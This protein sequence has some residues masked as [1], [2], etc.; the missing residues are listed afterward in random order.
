MFMDQ[1]ASQ[2]LEQ[3]DH[4]LEFAQINYDLG[5]YDIAAV[6]VS[7]PSRSASKA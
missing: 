1:R 5:G 2:W 7:S 4:E 3:A 6:S